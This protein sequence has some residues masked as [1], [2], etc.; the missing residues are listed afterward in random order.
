MPQETPDLASLTYDDVDRLVDEDPIKLRDVAWT[1]LC[2]LRAN[3]GSGDARLTIAEATIAR[4]TGPE[5]RE[6][7]ARHIHHTYGIGGWDW[8][9]IDERIQDKFRA[10]A[11]E[12]MAVIAGTGN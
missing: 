5:A 10:Q 3:E 9:E 1:A 12:A 6:R 7:L 8:E 2:D 4:L 11:D